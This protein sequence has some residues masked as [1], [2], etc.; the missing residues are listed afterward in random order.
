MSR[1]VYFQKDNDY[2]YK[3]TSLLQKI[4]LKGQNLSLSING[5]ELPVTKRDK[6][7][8][9]WDMKEIRQML[10]DEYMINDYIRLDRTISY[11]NFFAMDHYLKIPKIEFD[12]TVFTENL[13]LIVKSDKDVVEG[14]EFFFVSDVLSN[15]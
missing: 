3:N 8:V 9:E 10:R 11:N 6:E 4:K 12:N 15:N 1:N 5:I 2:K 14:E 7:W 13:E